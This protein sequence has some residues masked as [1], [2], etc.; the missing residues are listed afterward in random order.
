M[1]SNQI[2][3]IP[4]TRTI[5]EDSL[6]WP[7][8]QSGQYTTKSGYYFLK[9]EA[10]LV[11]SQSLSQAE[12]MKPLWKRIWSLSVPCKVRNFL[13][14]ACKNA[15]PTLNNL[16]RHCVVEESKCSLCAQHEEDVIHAL[17]SFPALAQVWNEDPQ[18]SFIGQN[19][20]PDFSHLINLVF[21]SGCSAE[22]FAMQ[23]WTIWFRR[24]KVRSA[25]LGFPLNLIVQRT[26]EALVEYRAAQPRHSLV[27]PTTRQWARWIPLLQTAF[28]LLLS[29]VV[30]A[31]A[32]DYGNAPKPD[33]NTP[34][35]EG[36]YNPDLPKIPD[37]EKPNLPEGKD[38]LL[39][40]IFGIQGLVLCKSGSQYFPLE[41]N[42][43]V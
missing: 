19:V 22:L 14:R 26:Y 36:N 20:F 21:K 15:I 11:N 42:L 2:V 34:K 23:S 18:W 5:S 39:P 6:F 1:E 35:P 37:Y 17:W 4:L 12:L 13:R 27:A 30:I 3:K 29:L 28:M 9:T 7:Y 38:E 43:Y 33:Y 40:T 24:N 25:P 41:G 16:K 32:N 10:Q 31:S 8:V